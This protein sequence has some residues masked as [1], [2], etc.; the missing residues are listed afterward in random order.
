MPTKSA[1]RKTRTSRKPP[2]NGR[3]KY[4]SAMPLSRLKPYRKNPRQNDDAVEAVA[5]SIGQF[6]KIAPI[7]VNEELRICA[8]HTR[9]KAALERNEKTFPTLVVPGLTGKRFRAYNIADNQT[10]TIA[11]WDTPELAKIIKKL[12]AED[13]PIEALGFEDGQLEEL[14]ASIEDEFAG[15]TD[16]DD[17]PEAPK[18]AITKRGDLWLLGDHKLMCG[19]STKPEDIERLMDGEKALLMVTDPPYGVNYETTGKNPRWRKDR[20]PIAGDNL[21]DNQ[22]SFWT[23]AFCSWPLNGDCYSFG[24]SGPPMLKLCDALKAA[25]VE[26]H[27]W[28]IWVKQ[29]FVLG[30]GHYH[31]RHEHI[32]YGWKGHSSWQRSRTQ[33]SVWEADRPLGSPEH[34]TMKPVVLCQKAIGNSSHRNAIVI[35]PF[36]GSATM[37]AA[38]KLGRKCYGMEIE[39]IYVDVS[40]QRWQNFTGKKAVLIRNGKQSKITMPV[41]EGVSA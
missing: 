18:K 28:L 6:G 8:G 17:V 32:F 11:Q 14:L 40:V 21:G 5:R 9:F 10:A 41:L 3:P 13:F 12:Q 15:K 37:I 25:G 33:D 35:D 29:Q 1:K 30:R 4:Y 31:Y 26:H 38:E 2:S 36:L 39:P 19:N 16:P 22:Q 23:I 24:P 7:I 27:Q 20:K 34:P